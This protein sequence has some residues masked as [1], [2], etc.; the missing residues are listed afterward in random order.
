[1]GD[2]WKFASVR[3]GA[4]LVEMDGLLV[5]PKLHADNWGLIQLV[6][7]AHGSFHV[8]STQKKADSFRF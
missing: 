1:M 5:T 7:Y 2:Y 6:R 3:D 8:K 4:L